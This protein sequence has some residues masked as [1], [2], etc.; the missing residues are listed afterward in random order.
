[1]ECN[2]CVRIL[3]KSKSNSTQFSQNTTINIRSHPNSFHCRLVE[4]LHICFRCRYS[5][6]SHENSIRNLLA[7]HLDIRLNLI[8]FLHTIFIRIK[9]KS[10]LFTLWSNGF[11]KWSRIIACSCVEEIKI[12]LAHI[13]FALFIS[14]I[15]S[16]FGTFSFRIFKK[17][18]F[19]VRFIYFCC[20]FHLFDGKIE[21]KNIYV[22]Y[23]WNKSI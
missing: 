7:L 4:Y 14:L 5:N 19:Y 6:A 8:Y 10:S 15:F 9:R 20:F 17:I 11:W 2:G 1:M 18:N 3:W 16:L 23:K 21:K 13:L 22:L 12:R